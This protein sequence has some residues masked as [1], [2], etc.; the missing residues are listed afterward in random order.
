MK[1]VTGIFLLFILLVFLLI[2][3]SQGKSMDTTSD[4]VSAVTTVNK[5][6]LV[7]I[8]PDKDMDGKTFT[9]FTTNW[10]GYEPLGHHDILAEELTGEPIND[11]AFNRNLKVMS[12]YNC[13][14]EAFDC[15]TVD[16]PALLRKAN[17]AGDK[18]YDITLIRG[19]I[20]S[21]LI[22][23]GILLD[24]T[25]MP[26][27]DFTKP[28]WDT[29]SYDDLSILGRHYGLRGGITMTSMLAVWNVCFNKNMIADYNLENP[30]QIVKDGKWTFNKAYNMG[31]ETVTDLNGNGK[32]DKN[33]RYGI[34]YTYNTV[35]GML[36]CAGVKIAEINNEG[37]PE[38][39]IQNEAAV[40]RMIDIFT[41]L[42]DTNVCYNTLINDGGATDTDKFSQGL[43]L[44]VF[45]AGHTVNSLRKMDD[46]DFGMIPYPKYDEEQTDYISTTCGVFLSLVSVPATNTDLE[47]TG[48]FM[49]AYAYEGN[50]NIYPAFYDVLLQG[51]VAR[52]EETGE[53][54][55]YIYGNISYD[56]GSVFNFNDFV[57]TIEN[58]SKTY[59]T[60]VSSFLAKNIDAVQYSIDDLITKLK[61]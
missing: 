36:N 41:D 10:Y 21:P 47:N 7:P 58:F 24:L 25:D 18:S 38:L 29:Q 22:S 19:M 46:I 60:N 2:A 40:T 14:I 16:T 61:Y 50:K 56:I 6:D 52:D 3:C 4:T 23:E 53:M 11:A 13:A 57:T 48:I 17:N 54:L 37:I 1:K 59:D 9:V 12:Q 15:M 31:K 42:F 45:T 30:Y 33:D 5:A 44:F 28:W 20:F 26:Y 27:V 8:L 51:K 39:K 35:P 34:T 43:S 55:D 49:E 32:M